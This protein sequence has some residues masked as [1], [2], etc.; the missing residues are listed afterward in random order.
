MRKRVATATVVAVCGLA[1]WGFDRL[2]GR[3]Y[4]L[5]VVS[6]TNLLALAPSDY[7]EHNILVATL[8]PGASLE[9]IRQRYGKDF[10]TFE[11]TTVEGQTG[12]VVEGPALVVLP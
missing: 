12:W 3:S 4:S 9:V 2:D 6:S 1:V 5:R 7:P 11:V 8:A 10:R